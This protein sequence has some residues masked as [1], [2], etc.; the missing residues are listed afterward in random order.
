VTALPHA[1]ACPACG[2]PILPARLSLPPIKQRILAIVQ[3]RPGITAAQLRE[4]VWADAIDGGPENFKTIHVHINQLNKLTAPLGFI[5]R[6]RR[7]C[8]HEGY[9]IRRPP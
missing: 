9:R 3:R 2:Q 6:A 5:V 1:L 8:A 4:V 7:G